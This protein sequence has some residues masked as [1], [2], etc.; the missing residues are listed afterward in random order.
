MVTAW[1]GGWWLVGLVA[2]ITLLALGEYYTGAHRQGARPAT[3]LGYLAALALLIATQFGGD[4]RDYLVTLILVLTVMVCLMLACGRRQYRGVLTDLAVT[5]FG[6]IYVGL[7]MSFYLRLC[8]LDLPGLSGAEHVLF[9]GAVSTLLLILLPIWVLDTVAFTVGKAWGR[10]Q[11]A[12]RLS[13]KK[14]VEGAL[15]GFLTAVLTT[16]LLGVFWNHM[17]WSHA[18]VLGGL[19]GVFAQVGDLAESLLKR[20]L[21]LKD[22]GTLFGPHGGVLDRF[23][24]VLFALPVAYLYLGL[25]FV[26]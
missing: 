8:Q 4:R 5:L 9:G 6:V 11:L 25:V 10:L 21:G 22:F 20:D 2:V 14:T 15:A 19:I 16:V 13:P 3:G 24:G 26:A 7:G 1:A 18:L 23:D 12:P 17:L